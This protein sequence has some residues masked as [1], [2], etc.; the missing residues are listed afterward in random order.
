MKYGRASHY[1]ETCSSYL[2]ID[3]LGEASASALHLGTACYYGGWASLK[4]WW[5]TRKRCFLFSLCPIS[6]HTIMK[7]NTHKMHKYSIYT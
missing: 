2:V 3:G 7:V 5:K 6:L 4:Q 1:T